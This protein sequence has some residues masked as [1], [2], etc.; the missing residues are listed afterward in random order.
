MSA[1]RRLC[2]FSACNI[3]GKNSKRKKRPGWQI[4]P[5]VAKSAQILK[6]CYGNPPKFFTCTL[7]PDDAQ[8]FHYG[9]AL[10]DADTPGDFQIGDFVRVR[11]TSPLGYRGF[12]VLARITAGATKLTSCHPVA[13]SLVNVA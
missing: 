10:F 9:H 6:E 1:G 5:R 7:R 8:P 11:A 2:R 3:D 12:T 13:V 4:D